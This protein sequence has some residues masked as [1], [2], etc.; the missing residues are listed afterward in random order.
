MKYELTHDALRQL[1]E[2]EVDRLTED[3]FEMRVR[4][5]VLGILKQCGLDELMRDVSKLDKLN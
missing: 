4:A 2:D 1:V 3:A 5:E